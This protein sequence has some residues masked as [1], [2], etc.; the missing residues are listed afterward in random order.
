MK[1]TWTPCP[2]A[3]KPHSVKGY[4]YLGPC[5]TYT[6]SHGV[7]RTSLAFIEKPER[8]ENAWFYLQTGFAATHRVVSGDLNTS[9]LRHLTPLSRSYSVYSVLTTSWTRSYRDYRQV[10][11]ACLKFAPRLQR[12]HYVWTPFLAF[13]PRTKAIRHVRMRHYPNT[14]LFVLKIIL[15]ISL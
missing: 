9:A 1:Y 3:W 6:F 5:H 12:P 7:L 11:A 4:S 2:R 14:W 15:H 10:H 13:L 8:G